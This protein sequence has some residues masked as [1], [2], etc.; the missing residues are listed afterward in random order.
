MISHNLKTLS[1]CDQVLDL[2]NLK[3]ARADSII[4]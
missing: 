3:N 2:D 1:Y 4:F